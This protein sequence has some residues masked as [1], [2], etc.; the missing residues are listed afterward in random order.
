MHLS[1]LAINHVFYVPQVWDLQKCRMMHCVQTIASVAR[2]RWRP[3]RKYHIASCSLLV[4][5]SI[6]IWDIRRPYIPFASFEEHKDVAKGILAY[7]AFR[8]V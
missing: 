6:N 3:Q 5:S 7:Q 2:I 8:W 4:D 1:T